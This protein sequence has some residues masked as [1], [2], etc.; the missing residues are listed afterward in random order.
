MA[1]K[2]T[3]SWEN[4]LM[5]GNETWSSPGHTFSVD[6]TLLERLTNF[7]SKS[8]AGVCNPR[9]NNGPMEKPELIRCARPV[10]ERNVAFGGAAGWP[11][12]W[13][14]QRSTPRGFR[15][16]I[17]RRAERTW[18]AYPLGALESKPG[19]VW[20]IEASSR[21]RSRA[22]AVTV[23]AD[24]KPGTVNGDK[25]ALRRRRRGRRGAR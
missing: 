14:V 19:C 6:E 9:Y 10:F 12:S 1:S 25:W 20:T 3:N 13:H 11:C 4:L 22:F 17:R 23:V 5:C 2:T 18:H 7:I 16:G 8:A 24:P 21:V 15:G